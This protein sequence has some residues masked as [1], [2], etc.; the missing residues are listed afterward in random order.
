MRKVFLAAILYTLLLSACG[1]REISIETTAVGNS[2]LPEAAIVTATPESGLSLNSKSEEIRQAMLESATKWKSVWMDGTIT[3]YALEGTDSQITTIHEQDWIDPSTNRFRILMGPIDG[4]AE[5]FMASDGMSILEMDLPSGQSQSRPLPDFVKAG[6]FVPTP[7]PDTAFPQPLWRQIGT[8]LSQL[9]FTSDFAQSAGTFV[10]V[11]TESVAGRQALVVDWT[12]AQNQLPSWRM[13][14]DTNTGVIL[15]MQTYDKQG[16]D[17]VRSE[18]V[19]N[20]ISFDDVFADALFKNPSLL[21]EFSDMAGIP[22]KPVESAPANSSAP[23]P[24]RD[25]YFFVFDHNYGHEK[26]QLVRVPGSCA[27]GL[28]PCPEAEEISPPS[29]LKFS[30]TSLVWSPD[31]KVAAFPYPISA[32][33]NRAALFLFNPQE[34]SWKSIAEFNFID[35][36]IWSPDGDWLAFRAQDGAGKDEIYNVHPD[37]TELVNISANE[38]L[39]ADGQPYVLNGWIN[40]NIILRGRNDMVYLVRADYPTV[41]LLF[42]TPWKKSNFVPSPDGYFLAYVDVNDQSAA[43][44]LLTPDGNMTR[45]LAAFDKASIY[46][47]VWSPDGKQVAFVKM[48]NDI[49]MGQDL[50]IIGTNGHGLQQV[51][52]SDTSGM[53]DLG[54]SLDGKYLTFEDSDATGRHIFVIDLSTMEKHMLTVPNLPLDWWWI[55]PSWQR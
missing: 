42:D 5:K 15:K 41:R 37:G 23:D 21:P 50:Y 55:A 30:V 51:Y 39:P 9:A 7:Q 46:P 36:P 35:P 11:T 38:K 6:Q 31:G 47:V 2:V 44:K 19:V 45:Q 10:P 48:T 22:L 12:F 17:T 43:L 28:I 33:G 34:R 53:I 3:D 14:L 32:D 25:V 54:Y 29:D 52:H 16:G 49:A 1:T 24:L 4:E 40:N 13:W 18:A 26:T 27:A 20:Q 8:P